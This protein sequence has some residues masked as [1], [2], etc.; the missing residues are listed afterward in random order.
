VHEISVMQSALE[1]AQQEAL[2]RG[3]THIHCITLRVGRLAGVEPVA[4]TFAFEVVTAGTMAEGASLRIESVPI[5]C[6]CDQCQKEFMPEDF[7]F[8]CPGCGV[9]SQNVRAGQELELINLEVSGD[10]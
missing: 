10:E 5:V 7:V 2:L 3:A 6:Y 9:L 4:L 1:I 8:A